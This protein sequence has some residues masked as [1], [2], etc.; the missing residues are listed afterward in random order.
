[1]ESSKLE[2]F[3]KFE[4]SAQQSIIGGAEEGGTYKTRVRETNDGADT[5]IG[6]RQDWHLKWHTAVY[7]KIKD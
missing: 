1:M 3:K 6:R 5:E 4:I 2:A 7:E